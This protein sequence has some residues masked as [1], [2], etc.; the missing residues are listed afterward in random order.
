MVRI[1]DTRAGNP[2]GLRGLDA[3]CNGSPL[4][5]SGTLSI[6]VAGLAGVP[7]SGVRA[8]VVNL[9]G[10]SPSVPTFLTILPNTLPSPLVSDLDE[11][12]GD[13]RA[14]LV[15]ATLSST[16]TITIYNLAGNT[17]VVVDVL[18]WYS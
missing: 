5:P 10:V 3:Q 12:P 7:E 9:T 18:G 16:G 6:Q 11:V 14:N 15:V 1:C 4:G 8:V 17:D 13:V 2:S